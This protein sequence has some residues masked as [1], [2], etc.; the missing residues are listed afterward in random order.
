MKGS[1]ER[2]R[3]FAI[4]EDRKVVHVRPALLP[5]QPAELAEEDLQVQ[6]ALDA[7]C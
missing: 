2:H 6:L 4:L 7:A 3:T 1:K 5:A